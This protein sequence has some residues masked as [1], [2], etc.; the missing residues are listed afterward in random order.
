MQA[1]QFE[2]AIDLDL[3]QIDV[4]NIEVVSFKNWLCQVAVRIVHLQTVISHKTAS[5]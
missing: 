5:H 1:I 2:S 4:F 3:R